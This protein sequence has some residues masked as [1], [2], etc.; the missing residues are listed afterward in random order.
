MVRTV[1]YPGTNGTGL[2]L[3]WDVIYFDDVTIDED[4]IDC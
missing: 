4:C 3:G 1:F 2:A